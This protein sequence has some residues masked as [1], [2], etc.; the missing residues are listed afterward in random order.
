M[1]SPFFLTPNYKIYSKM[2][3]YM[4]PWLLGWLLECLSSMY[5]CLHIEHFNMPDYCFSSVYCFY[6]QLYFVFFCSKF[7]RFKTKHV[8]DIYYFFNTVTLCIIQYIYTYVYM[9]IWMRENWDIQYTL[10]SFSKELT[11]LM[12]L[13]ERYKWANNIKTVERSKNIQNGRKLS[14]LIVS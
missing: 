9:E 11:R 2:L 8:N 1:E 13:N 14:A 5:A 7:R 12:L 3:L 6:C 4:P 10:I